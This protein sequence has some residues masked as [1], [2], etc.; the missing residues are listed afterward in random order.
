MF[1]ISATNAAAETGC[2]GPKTLF[3][4]QFQDD[5]GG[6]ALS[7]AVKIGDGSFDVQLQP[8]GMLANLNVSHTVKGD[9][10]FCATAVWPDDN[11]GILGAGV[12]FWGE[13]AKNYF[14]F[15]VLNTGKY[16]LARKRKG[17]WQ[18]IVNSAP[19]DAIDTTPGATNTLRVDASGNDVS[20]YVN[21]QK[22]QELRGQQPKGGWRFGLSGDNFD[23]KAS[24]ELNFSSVK[25]T[26]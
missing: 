11:S 21:D 9:V 19:S 7:S 15:G 1:C 16:W 18:V 8:N 2:N 25:V 23:T 5:A 3:T 17:E 12:L 24:A 22:L 20:L 26:N 4:D 10:N 13:D 6:W 14:Q